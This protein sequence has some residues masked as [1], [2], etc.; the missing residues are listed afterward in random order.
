MEELLLSLMLLMHIPSIS[1]FVMD[2]MLL[3]LVGIAL[4]VVAL[5]AAVGRGRIVRVPMTPLL[6]VRFHGDVHGIDEFLESGEI[7]L[8]GFELATIVGVPP[9][10]VRA[11][12]YENRAGG[13]ETR[14]QKNNLRNVARFG[15]HRQRHGI[16][17]GIHRYRVI[18]AFL[19]VTTQPA[20]ISVI[21]FH[22]IPRDSSLP[23]CNALPTLLFLPS[24]LPSLLKALEAAVAVVG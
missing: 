9:A 10:L 3:L 23:V 18:I 6:H 14:R 8:L 4:N 11:S 15:I 19:S 5:A 17:G 21:I 12:D 1:I 2:V 22:K 16:V 20:F 24:S 13:G 7:L